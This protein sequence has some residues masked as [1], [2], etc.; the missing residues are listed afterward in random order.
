MKI[1]RQELFP[2]CSGNIAKALEDLE[3]EINDQAEKLEA[4]IH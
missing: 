2:I 3:E 4:D 1:A